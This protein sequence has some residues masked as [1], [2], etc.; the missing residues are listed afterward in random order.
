LSNDA[1]KSKV[2]SDLAN[3]LD[4]LFDEDDQEEKSVDEKGHS[5]DPLD[6]LKSLVMSIEWEITDDV[7][8]RFLS[9][10]DSLKTRLGE[11][12]ILIM[13]LQ[14]LGSLGL[15]VKTNKG[16]AH[17]IAFKL[18]NSVY[19]SF[20]NAAS[21]G[22]ISPSEKKKLLY[23][24]L[25]KYKELKEQ[26]ESSRGPE[27]EPSRPPAA[28]VGALN[29]PQTGGGTDQKAT[30]VGNSAKEATAVTR[31]Y[32]DE[33]IRELKKVILKEFNAIRDDI[34]KLEKAK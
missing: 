3:R 31:Q 22:K 16:K 4:T 21:P 28:A 32:F 12:R 27:V 5:K 1:K 23:L 6:E 10:I 25:N 30:P 26:I 17:P 8:E 24:E 11:D 9:Q 18:L 20:E 15:Y 34:A 29:D 7:M 19:N 33:A 14:L 2:D 13:F